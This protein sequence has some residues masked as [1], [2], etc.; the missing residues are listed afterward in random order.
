MLSRLLVLLVF[1][2]LSFGPIAMR[3]DTILHWS[4]CDRESC[5]DFSLRVDYLRGA[6][7]LKVW[8]GRGPM[9]ATTEVFIFSGCREEDFRIPK[10]CLADPVVDGNLAGVLSN[11][12]SKLL[13]DVETLPSVLWL[14]YVRH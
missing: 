5:A 7:L 1:I 8:Q 4:N 10:V 14:P 3:G 9:N 2:P 13:V 12:L 6:P 11:D